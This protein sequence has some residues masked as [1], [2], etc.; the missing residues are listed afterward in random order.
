MPAPTVTFPVTGTGPYGTTKEAAEGAIDDAFAAQQLVID[1]KATAAQGAK[2]DTAVQ[3]GELG[4]AAGADTGDFATAAQGAKAD[5]AVQ[6]ESINNVD[7]T[8]D[9]D[10]PVSGPQQTALDAKA[11]K[12]Q[13]LSGGGL[14]ATSG[15]LG[16]DPTVAVTAAAEADVRLGTAADRAI[17]PAALDA[18]LMER[19]EHAKV[20][21]V[22]NMD[23]DLVAYVYGAGMADAAGR[24]GAWVGATG[25]TFRQAT[26][27]GDSHGDYAG[28]ITPLLRGAGGATFMGYD[29]AALA[30][31]FARVVFGGAIMPAPD[32]SGDYA[33][34]KP[35]LYA[36]DG[37]TLLLG[38]DADGLRLTLSDQAIYTLETKRALDLSAVPVGLL[39]DPEEVKIHSAALFTARGPD[40]TGTNRRY[41]MRRDVTPGCAMA[42]TRGPVEVVTIYGQSYTTG[43]GG[44][45]TNAL[46]L[47]TIV[48]EDALTPHHDLMPI[49][50]EPGTGLIST[51]AQ[52]VDGSAITDLVPCVSTEWSE[53]SPFY[54]GETGFPACARFLR[55]SEQAAGLPN[56]TRVW[57]SHGQ[58]GASITDLDD[59]GSNSYLNGLIT[60]QRIKDVAAI[61]GRNIIVRDWNWSQGQ[62]DGGKTRQEYIDLFIALR[63]QYLSD[64]AAITGQ[65]LG[66]DPVTVWMDQVA[67]SEDNDGRQVSLSQLDLM[68]EN[69][70]D[71]YLTAPWYFL[72]YV[73]EIHPTPLAYAVHRE[74]N[75]KV[76]R[77]VESGG[78][79]TGVRPAGPLV[80]DGSTIT[81]PFYNQG[82]E[83]VVDT[84]TLPQA[85]GWG[86]ELVGESETIDAIDIL[87]GDTAD[88]NKIELTLS[89]APTVTPY[90]RYAYTGPVSKPGGR[91]GA[92]GNIRNQDTTPSLSEPGRN[93]VD[94][95]FISD[96]NPA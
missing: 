23:P 91:S 92:W 74:Y 14:A 4:T 45:D 72:P 9:A 7:N 66:D 15:T 69:P 12:T 96:A 53:V 70:G 39:A 46:E 63:T 20:A 32:A 26:I 29:G 3:P 78:T 37:K 56:I 34:V 83:L 82:S 93:L 95:A 88:Q 30:A 68:T 79:W 38:A 84:T 48:T 6:P 31:Y 76:K 49:T 8:S 62:A 51:G 33:V 67:P 65:N 19:A 44:S 35:I 5:T 22:L 17:T 43:G 80:V 75:A 85:P 47:P 52:L 27:E 86:F 11:D 50:T 10:K 57:Y 94:W 81:V 18:P 55:R 64:I 54:G 58:G 61:Y 24:L 16:A 77:I 25:F 90:L 71:I 73:D 36:G 40:E 60:L 87:P 41:L 1:S 21:A 2:A 13:T 42:E 59:T 89:G 28:G